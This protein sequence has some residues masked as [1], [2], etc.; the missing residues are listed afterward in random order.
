MTTEQD[1]QAHRD[2]CQGIGVESPFL[3][4][5]DCHGVELDD[6]CACAGTGGVFCTLCWGISLAVLVDGEPMCT[7]CALEC[8]AD[9]ARERG[10]DLEANWRRE[11]EP[12]NC[13]S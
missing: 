6:D 10:E 13:I 8:A 11:D 3:V 5:P 7:D 9:L 12:D 1:I 4:C 2:A